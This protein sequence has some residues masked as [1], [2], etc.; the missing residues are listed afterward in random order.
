MTNKAGVPKKYFERN[1]RNHNCIVSSK[2]KQTMKFT[3]FF[4]DGGTCCCCYGGGF[5]N[6]RR[7]LIAFRWDYDDMRNNFVVNPF[8]KYFVRIKF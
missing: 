6:T 5:G 2:L 1:N 4:F 3:E 8:L 7:F